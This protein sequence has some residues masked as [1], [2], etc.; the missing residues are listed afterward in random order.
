MPGSEPT[1]QRFS[2]SWTT[3]IVGQYAPLVADAATRE[4]APTACATQAPRCRRKRGRRFS[5]SARAQLTCSPGEVTA[6]Q[7]SPTATSHVRPPAGLCRLLEQRGGIDTAGI[8]AKRDVAYTRPGHPEPDLRGQSMPACRRRDGSPRPRSHAA[9]RTLALPASPRR[10]SRGARRNRRP[11]R[12]YSRHCEPDVVDRGECRTGC[13]SATVIANCAG[14][15]HRRRSTRRWASFAAEHIREAPDLERVFADGR[16]IAVVIARAECARDRTATQLGVDLERQQ[17][18]IGP[19]VAHASFAASIVSVCMS[20]HDRTAC[21]S[22]A[23]RCTTSRR[24]NAHNNPRPR[25][26]L[27]QNCR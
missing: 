13:R 4:A 19:S 11:A 5:R 23:R 2:S 12:P 24:R 17:R 10:S 6:R 26:A 14:S 7:S 22:R 3:G 16:A 15:D 27:L 9:A 21:P 1:R 20:I 25:L 8:L 18:E